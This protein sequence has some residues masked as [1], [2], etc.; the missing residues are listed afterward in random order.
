MRDSWKRHNLS[1]PQSRSGGSQY[2]LVTSQDVSSTPDEKP[3]GS[4]AQKLQ[5]FKPGNLT[6]DVFLIAVC[7]P[8]LVLLG[9][10]LDRHGRVVVDHD[11]NQIQQGM[12]ISVTAFPLVFSAVA[13]T[14]VQRFSAWKLERG[15]SI[16]TL[17]QLNGCST[18]IN[19]ITTLFSLRAVNI[20]SVV[21]IALWTFS[22]LGGQSSLYILRTRP[23]YNTE[24]IPLTYFN[25]TEDIVAL[26]ADNLSFDFPFANSLFM[27]SILA[28]GYA[29]S[30]TTDNLGY[31]KVP[32]LETIA[33]SANA[34]GW[35]EVGSQPVNYSSLLGIPILGIDR[36]GN[37]TLPMT[38]SYFQLHLVNSTGPEVPLGGKGFSVNTNLTAT[39]VFQPAESDYQL[40]FNLTRIFAETEI[41]CSS[42]TAPSAKAHKC[43]VTSMRRLPHTY[44]PLDPSIDSAKTVWIQNVIR[45]LDD[46]SSRRLSSTETYLIDPEQ[47]GGAN[48]ASATISRDDLLLRLAQLINTYAISFYDPKGFFQG[49]PSEEYMVNGTGIHTY[50][51]GDHI[52]EVVWPWMG[53]YMTATLM[54]VLCA[55]VLTSLDPLTLNPEILGYAST[56]LWENQDPRIPSH[57]SAMSGDVRSKLFRNLVIRFGDVKESEAAVGRLGVGLV[58]TVTAAQKKRLYE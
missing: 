9:I 28:P 48:H 24:K 21:L 45:S 26:G 51:N 42:D 12:S 18:L 38:V 20:L 19:T 31:L 15:S 34:S 5:R 8:F 6:L 36:T 41:V 46:V 29:K 37:I 16:M 11:W 43:A 50:F 57:G 56:A 52:Y 49:K 32:I 13:G 17:E 30:S 1:A 40:A 44:N 58:D 10:A 33:P 4:G 2:E 14:L 25:S 22:P 47:A 53:V 35:F 7:T 23:S 55:L 3:S 39:A 54:M 27:A